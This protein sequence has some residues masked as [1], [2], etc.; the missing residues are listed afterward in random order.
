M[1]GKNTNKLVDKITGELWEETSNG[2]H[3]VTDEQEMYL[4]IS[5]HTVGDVLHR[6]F[7]QVFANASLLDIGSNEFKFETSDF[8]RENNI[9]D[10]Y[11]KLMFNDKPHYF[12]ATGIYTVDAKQ[13]KKLD[14]TINIEI[15][16]TSLG[17]YD[18]PAKTPIYRIGCD[19]EKTKFTQN[20]D[21][22]LINHMAE[23]GYKGDGATQRFK[24]L[25]NTHNY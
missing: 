20:E 5:S 8:D 21:I 15:E 13:I 1:I 3:K 16:C 18:Y 17:S 12:T 9:V 23:V 19:P 22:N 4:K 14:G 2:Y 7:F 6:D 10:H 25:Y 11:K 24:L